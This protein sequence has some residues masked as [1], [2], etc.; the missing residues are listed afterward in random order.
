VWQHLENGGA[1]IVFSPAVTFGKTSRK[2]WD[3][4]FPTEAIRHGFFI[5]GS[6][7]KGQE[8]NDGPVFFGEGYFVG[9]DGYKLPNISIFDNLIISDINLDTLKNDNSGWNLKLNQRVDLAKSAV[10]S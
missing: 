5:G 8:F 10:S 3:H 4:E 7:R 6:N 9:T 1:Q 2:A